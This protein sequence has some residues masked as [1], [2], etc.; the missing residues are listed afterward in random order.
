LYSDDEE[1]EAEEKKERGEEKEEKADTPAAP[2]PPPAA[3]AAARNQE[4][5]EIPHFQL[6]LFTLLLLLWATH[7]AAVGVCL[8]APLVVGRLLLAAVALPASHHDTLAMLLGV[9][10]FLGLVAGAAK[11]GQLASKARSHSPCKHTLSL[12]YQWVWLGLRLCVVAV[13]ALVLL[14]LCVG[15]LF[16]LVAVLPVRV[17]PDEEVCF[18][19]YKDW[20][21]GLV[22]VKLLSRLVMSGHLGEVGGWKARLE[23]EVNRPVSAVSVRRVVGGIVLPLLARLGTRYDIRHDR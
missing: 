7:I 22:I 4:S 9:Y 14:P 18:F 15:V 19:L 11:V 6:R 20:V 13:F 10:F 16:D 17:P 23:A 12:T 1:Q 8:V 5:Y 3:A 2:A 21:V